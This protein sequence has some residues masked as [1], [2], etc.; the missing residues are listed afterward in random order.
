MAREREELAIHEKLA[1]CIQLAREFISDQ[2]QHLRELEAGILL[3]FA[4]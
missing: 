2:R 1:R 3:S 4:D